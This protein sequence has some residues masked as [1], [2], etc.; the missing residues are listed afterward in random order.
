MNVFEKLHEAMGQEQSVNLSPAE[1]ELLY[2]LVG[3]EIAKAET[4][5]ERWKEIFKDF[6][7]AE[8]LHERRVAERK[9]ADNV[10][11]ETGR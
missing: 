9:A 10:D 2:R 8:E 7:H 5:Y 6:D 3:D 4:E 1:V 11:G